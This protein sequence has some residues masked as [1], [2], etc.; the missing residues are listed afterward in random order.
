[1]K[2]H[3][4]AVRSKTP[5]LTCWGSNSRVDAAEVPSVNGKLGL[6]AGDLLFSASPIP[7]DIGAPVIAAQVGPEATYAVTEDGSVFAWGSNEHAEL[8]IEGQM[9]IVRTP[10][11]L[12]ART[13]TGLAPVREAADLIRS[14]GLGS[15]V[16]MANRTAF[17]VSYLCWGTDRWGE[18]GDGTEKGARATHRYPVPVRALAGTAAWV[19][20]GEE[21][22]CGG[23]F[24][25]GHDEV[26]CYGRPGLLGNGTELSEESD[27]PSH[28]LG[29]P[30]VWAP[31][32]FALALE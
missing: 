2:N 1:V 9:T 18:V 17:G 10:S 16:V 11:P 28:W 31:A 6:A 22:A 27:P 21:H 29:T 20:R 23:G 5:T 24:I 14:A 30:V 12:V 19:G 13:A 3:T 4:C 8:G 7:V 15:C 32:N 25:P 26:L